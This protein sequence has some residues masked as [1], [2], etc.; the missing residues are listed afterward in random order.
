MNDDDFLTSEFEAHRGHLRAVAYRMLG[1]I[2]EAEDAVQETWIK[3]SAAD[4]DNI[5]NLGGW[6]TTVTSRV[7][8]NMLRSRRTRREE[9]LD[10]AHLPDPIVAPLGDADDPETQA[11]LA[12]SV[13]I[14]L[15][16]VLEQLSP[17]ERLA[18]VLHDLFGM[19][20][21]EVAR[22]VD[23]TP[24]AA[25][26]LASRARMRVQG[27]H[28]GEPSLPQQRSVV[29]AFVAAARGGDLEALVAVLDPSIIL[30]DDFASDQRP[31]QL[32]GS[33][34]V[35]RGAVLYRS[36]N[37]HSKLVA[38]NG[39]IGIL[40]IVDGKVA[41]IAAFTVVGEHITEMNIVSD[42]ERLALM[43]FSGVL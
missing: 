20:F 34:K 21:D 12:D 14:A 11:L 16:V 42:P 17:G 22:I 19:P 41:A 23:K 5:D 1:S 31:H 30:R 28:P 2:P 29:E 7:C 32:V 13:S 25:R 24:A 6:L 27:A 43:D 40:T 10:V 8:L 3:A 18:F 38:A 39:G 36:A 15:L 37:P 33:E 4:Q 9:L 26:K 35:A